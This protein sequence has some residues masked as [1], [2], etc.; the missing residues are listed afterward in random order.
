MV[1]HYGH[2]EPIW[3]KVRA[4]V[5]VETFM[6]FLKTGQSNLFYE[7]IGQGP[8]IVWVGGGGSM[9]RDWQRFQTPHFAPHFRN[10]TFDNRGIG[11]TACKAPMPWSMADFARDLATLVEQACTPP[12]ALV[13]TSLGSAIVQQLAI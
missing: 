4:P 10:T 5:G 13:G 9:G 2:A 11:Q 1:T 3:S 12:V 7:Q 6:A 8:D